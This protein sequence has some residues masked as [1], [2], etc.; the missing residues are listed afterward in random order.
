MLFTSHFR[1][2]F[3]RFC[4]H[5]RF[6]F[7][8]L[9]NR[10]A[11][12]DWKVSTSGTAR[13]KFYIRFSAEL[14]V[15]VDKRRHK[16][17]GKTFESCIRNGGK[18]ISSA[19]PTNHFREFPTLSLELHRK[20]PWLATI[21]FD[22]IKFIH[23]LIAALCLSPD[24]SHDCAIDFR[25][26]WLSQSIWSLLSSHYVISRRMKERKRS[27]TIMARSAFIKLELRF[28]RFMHRW[29]LSGE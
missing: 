17:E 29:I 7:F 8:T 13:N 1:S 3:D 21:I 16:A 24:K 28:M 20:L 14:I 26:K 10:N 11:R 12:I 25:F 2:N 5:F 4:H 19:N 9:E 15:S 23:K 22:N 18:K 6:L 27:A